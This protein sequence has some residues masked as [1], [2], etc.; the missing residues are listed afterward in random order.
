M[1]GDRHNLTGTPITVTENVDEYRRL[2]REILKPEDVVLELGSAQGVSAS[3]M[4]KYCKE[5][6]GVDKSLLQHAAAVERFP[7]SEYPN[8]SYVVLDAFD[9]NAVRKLDKKFNKIFIDI[10]GNRCIGDVTEIIDRYEKIFKPELFVVKCFPLKR[11]INQ[12]TLYP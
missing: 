4:S 9:V 3:I 6:V 2:M 11:L 5:V 7:A 10:S 12:C 1:K 8:L